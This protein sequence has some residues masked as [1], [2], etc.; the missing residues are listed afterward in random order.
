[1]NTQRHPDHAKVQAQYVAYLQEKL[2][3]LP[4]KRIGDTFPRTREEWETHTAKLR[5][6]LRTIFD[7]PE[8]SGPLCPRTVGKIERDDFTIEK[9]IYDAEPGS[10]VP[11]HLFLP[12]GVAFPVPALIF[13]SGHGGS[14]SA[15]Y[16]H[17]A[18]QIYAKAGI[19]CLIPDPVGEEER[20][21]ENRPG[22]RGHR[23]DF[24]IDRCFEVGRSVIGKMTY[25]ITRGI[26]Y[27]CIRPEVD[28]DR[29]GC[30]GHSLGCTI[31]M[32]V[33]CTDNRLALSLPASWVTHFDYIVG[34]LSC[35]W[36]PYRLKHHVDMPEQI[37]MGAPRCATLILAGEWDYPPHAYR[38]LLETC[39]QVQRVYDICDAADR[40]DIDI[41]PKGGHRPYFLNKP[42]F[43]WVEKHLG[44]PKFDAE[45][46]QKLPEVYLGDWTDT[47]GIDIESGYKSH[48]HYAGTAV[49]DLNVAPVPTDELTCLP[50]KGYEAPE[51]AMRG[52]VASILK[53][54]PPELDIPQKLENWKRER[55]ILRETVAKV[56][57][58][59]ENR[60][61]IS[62]ETIRTFE[63][64]EFTAEEI[65]YGTLGLSSFLLTPK[66]GSKN[67]ALYLHQS[68]TKQGALQTGEV[69]HLIA[70]GTTVLALDCVGMDDSGM[71][72]GEPSTTAN[73]QHVM[74]ALDLLKQRDIHQATCYGYVD[75]IALY[76]AIL[77]NR[78]SEIILGARGGTEPHHQQRY[79][80]E[81]VVPYISR[82]IGRPGLLSLLAPRPLT[83]K[84]VERELDQVQ[85]VY[86]LYGAENRLRIVE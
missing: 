18:G 70:S 10:S 2:V 66:D 75:D 36:R 12:K 24:R 71:L 74:E 7:F 35:E 67:T 45:A 79:R 5:P 55:I 82:H 39:R 78:I 80:Q 47:H 15:F 1:M 25:D 73:V 51:F 81:G 85:K 4:E 34:D 46:V 72:L 22:I 8:T 86:S 83:V 14:K 20:D 28:T 42:A 58:V 77:D 59:P 65:R 33:L 56:L 63:E 19:I 29:I 38:G 16:N 62:P 9:V 6:L 32:N 49:I 44:M 27:L 3:Q 53:E 26:D 40:F 37:A 43:A 54:L 23:L 13:P 52:W 11:A 41:T 64:N 21:E 57:A 69:Q 84:I 17:Y 30:V 60:P 50:P 31:T 68:R 76:A 61:N 48:K